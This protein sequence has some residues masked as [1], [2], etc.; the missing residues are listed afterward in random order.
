MKPGL[1]TQITSLAL[2]AALLIGAAGL[3]PRINADR[4]ALNVF[5]GEEVTQNAPPE[6]AFWIQAFGAFRGLIVNF[7][8]MRAEDY[9]DNGRYYD[10]MNLADWI[11]KLQPHFPAVWE[12]QSWNMAWNISVTTFTPEERWHWVYNGARLLRDEGLPYNPRSINLY[13]QLAWI[14]NNKMGA[15]VDDFH[16]SY[17]KNW[18]YRMHML[19]G[20]PPNPLAGQFDVDAAMERVALDLVD[21]PLY[22]AAL[23][24]REVRERRTVEAR[25]NPTG[26]VDPNKLEL[27]DGDLAYEEQL[28][29]EFDE[30]VLRI[31]AIMRLL[32][33]IEAAPQTLEELYAQHPETREQVKALRAAGAPISDAPLDEDTYM[34]PGGL[35]ANFFVPYRSS[36]ESSMVELLT[37][38][39]RAG[40]PAQSPAAQTIRETLGPP[41][42]PLEA[43]PLVRF[44]QRKVLTEV[45]KNQ[46]A[47]MIQLVRQFG[48]IDWRLVDSQSL[49]WATMALERTVGRESRFE[50][51]K[52]NTMR[53]VW[54][55]LQ[56]MARRNNIAFQ[57]FPD[58]NRMYDSYMNWTPDPAFIAS[59]HEAYMRYAPKFNPRARDD[60]AGVGELF[61]SGHTNFLVEGIRTLYFSG[62]KE[63]AQQYYDTLRDLYGISFDGFIE[64]RYTKSLRDFVWDTY[65]EEGRGR[66]ADAVRVIAG[67]LGQSFDALSAGQDQRATE[68]VNQ[69]RDFYNDFEEEKKSFLRDRMKMPAFGQIWSDTLR[70]FLV[71]RPSTSPFELI[72]K[73]RVWRNAPAVLRY[74]TYND[75]AERLATECEY[76]GFDMSRAFPA[77]PGLE[78]VQAA[79]AAIAAEEAEAAAE[80]A[81]GGGQTP[82]QPRNPD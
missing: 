79:R 44:L 42:D 9:K 22:Q 47:R 68:L 35:F 21:D 76:Y 73:S 82:V 5:G 54:F 24:Q 48:P 70:Q 77:P 25:E 45:Y 61:R 28:N 15:D 26:A 67:L 18:A 40:A 49:Y 75:V 32:E 20:P 43:P 2:C 12:F 8:F 39:L 34:Q 78:E 3:A 50:D 46:P 71:F 65:F 4:A 52:T 80:E 27:R 17:K 69:A 19:L 16:M 51:D 31:D 30:D 6:Y 81:D 74:A 33:Q 62:R 11:C 13:K 37:P 59:M 64:E 58:P 36:G 7:A 10:A 66:R 1:L 38:E 63:A 55:S 57:P 29:D 60:G 41:T 72:Y 23:E 53:L 14:F 56:N